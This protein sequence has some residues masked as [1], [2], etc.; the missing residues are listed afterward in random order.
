[1]THRSASPRFGSRT[2]TSLVS[3]MKHRNH[4]GPQT[5]VHQRSALLFAIRISKASAKVSE[6]KQP[7][8]SFRYDCLFLACWPL[9]LEIRIVP[10]NSALKLRRIGGG[11]FV[12]NQSVGLER[13]IAMSKSDRREQLA[14]VIGGKLDVHMTAIARRAPSA[15]NRHVAD[16]AVEHHHEL[17]LRH[18]GNL[19][20][21]APHGACGYRERSIV[22]HEMYGDAAG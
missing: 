5:Q 22:L 17:G 20:V 2:K 3:P 14:P 7:A 4:Q 13:T 11:D 8:V 10:Q 16:A 15:I 1:M 19:G 6:A 21:Q 18:R 12:K 9:D